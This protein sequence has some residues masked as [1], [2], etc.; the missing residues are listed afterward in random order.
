M[1]FTELTV[2]GAFRVEPERH[3]D[4]RGFLARTWCARQFKARG[5][6]A[7]VAQTSVSLDRQRGTVRGLH[8]QT[9]PA[10]QTMLVRCT[11]G[12]VWDVV[13]DL[14]PASPSFL[15][16]AAVELDAAGG[17]AV[18]VPKGCAHG[19]LTLTDAAEVL[20]QVSE[21]PVPEYARGV[22]WN[23]PLFAIP[24][25]A[26]V[27]VVSERDRRYPDF[28]VAGRAALLRHVAPERCA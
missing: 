8:Y 1:T 27:L 20:C 15:A 18:Y 9:P 3:E 12:Q 24:W 11:S 7:R 5:L 26:P 25:P 19:F 22:R 13:L 17:A 28:T 6:V 23:D 2:R 14:R 21:D 4:E 10:E 16:H